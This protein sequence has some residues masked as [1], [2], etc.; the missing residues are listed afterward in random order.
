MFILTDSLMTDHTLHPNWAAQA[1]TLFNYIKFVKATEPEGSFVEHSEAVSDLG[2]TASGEATKEF[3]DEIIS[4]EEFS[5]KKCVSNNSMK[6]ETIELSDDDDVEVFDKNSNHKLLVA[7]QNAD[8]DQLRSIVDCDYNCRDQYG[9]TALDIACTLG[10]VEIV[11]FL[12]S[13]GSELTQWERIRG[14][15]VKKNQFDIINFIEKKDD[16]DV[17]IVDMTEDS[18]LEKCPDCGEIYDKNNLSAHR[19]KISHQ[20]S[21]KS[22]ENIKRNP[23]FQISEFNVGFKLMRKAGWDGTSGLGEE[24][25]GKLF[26]VKTIFKQDRRGLEAGDRKKSRI[27]HFGPNDVK[28]IDNRRKRKP[29]NVK[30]DKKV[31]KRGS[32]FR[33]VEI[34]K[35]Q[36]LREELASL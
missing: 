5:R 22:E 35:D 13:K 8:I 28:S 25:N 2:N 20:L 15:L 1:T 31:V 33:K 14:N 3:Y 16:E 19:A 4:N 29:F 21:R 6:Y 12:S 30:K 26:P 32:K 7:I 24:G 27:T 18:E 34:C 17:E 11:K 23:G 10:N 9:W 36:L